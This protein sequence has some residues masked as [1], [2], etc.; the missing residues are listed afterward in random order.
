MN[1]TINEIPIN[2]KLKNSN[3]KNDIYC[4]TCRKHFIYHTTG[5]C[6]TCQ[7]NS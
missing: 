1:D 6:Y 5:K 2:E 4:S 7:F 3:N